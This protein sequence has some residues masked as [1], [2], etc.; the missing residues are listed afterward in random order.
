MAMQSGNIEYNAAAKLFDY[1][2]L[3]VIPVLEDADMYFD[4]ALLAEDATEKERLINL[5]MGKYFLASKITPQNQRIYVQLARIYDYMKKDRLAKSSFFHAI[6]LSVNDSYTNYWFGEFYY[7]RRDYPRALKYFTVAYNNG[8]SNDYTL[9]LRLAVIYEKFADLIN[10]ARFYKST[11]AINSE[12]V[13]LQEKIQAIDALNYHN[14][15]YYHF[16]RE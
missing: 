3:D 12:N 5:A 1:S 7:T 16:I 9:N 2:K 6:N 13:E 4:M 11:Y 14:S 15:E 10:A 8:F